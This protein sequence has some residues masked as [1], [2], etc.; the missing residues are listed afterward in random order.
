MARCR[1]KCE[2]QLT[3]I[4]DQR[5]EIVPTPPDP[6]IP[7][8]QYPT[9]TDRDAAKAAIDA[10]IASWARAI[11]TNGCAHPVPELPSYPFG[12]F[13]RQTDE[14]PTDAEWARKK[15]LTRQF[16]HEFTSRGRKWHI[17]TDVDYRIAYVAG[18]CEEP[19]NVPFFASAATFEGHDLVVMSASGEPVSAALRDKIKGVLG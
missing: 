14:D 16:R 8:D 5:T 18:A 4:I 3:R 19:P 1:G 11:T 12:C 6:A 13:C 17:V 15:L 10:D 2:L 7:L 9:K